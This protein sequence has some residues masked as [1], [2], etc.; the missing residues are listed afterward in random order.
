[1]A[2]KKIGQLTPLGRNLIATDELELSLAGSAGSRKITGAE[3]IGAAAG[4]SSV[5]G[6]SPIV[7]SGGSTPAISINVANASQN[8]YLSSID[9][10]TFNA[11]QVALVSGTNIKTINST[12]LLGSGDVSVQP[13]LVS[14]TNIKTINFLPVLGSGDIS[15]VS[16]LN[17]TSPINAS[18]GIGGSGNI[19]INQ[20][21]TSNNGYLSSTDWNTFNGKQPTLVSGTNIKT[22]NSTSLLGSGDLVIGGL[23]AWVETNATDLTLW[24]NGKGNVVSNTSFENSDVVITKSILLQPSTHSLGATVVSIPA[25]IPMLNLPLGVNSFGTVTSI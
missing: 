22:I 23:P 10:S 18:V 19:S 4:V 15:V 25:V 17:G 2:G 16:S 21:T 1:M 5:T 14:G 7:S 20:A 9:W 11:K 13:T 24:N 8:G 3:I 12:S 6:T